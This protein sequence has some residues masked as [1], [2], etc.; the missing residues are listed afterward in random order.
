MLAATIA[1]GIPRATSQAREGPDNAATFECG[2]FSRRTPH[3]VN[4]V[5]CSMP[6]VTLTAMP[7]KFARQRVTSRNALEGTATT[8]EA[9][10]E[11][12]AKLKAAV[13]AT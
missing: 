7:A 11:I 9:T 4:P 10:D 13:P 2:A 3:I 1:V 8:W 12:C 5:S 6:L